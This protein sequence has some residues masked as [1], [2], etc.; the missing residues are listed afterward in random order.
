MLKKLKQYL[1]LAKWAITKNPESALALIKLLDVPR[2]NM[3]VDGIP[4]EAFSPKFKVVS[5][6]QNK[7]L[8]AE[9]K[10]SYAL[11][12]G[13]TSHRFIEARTL[14]KSH[15]DEL[16]GYDVTS[17]GEKI[18]GTDITANLVDFDFDV[19]GAV[20]TVIQVEL[21][22]IDENSVDHEI[23]FWNQLYKI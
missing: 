14:L 4:A 9:V 23:K 7:K 1:A 11:P 21:R 20:N 17:A 15:G 8:T 10:Y 19:I 16:Y 18:P 22:Y 5:S 13:T 3:T 12:N 6:V 2:W